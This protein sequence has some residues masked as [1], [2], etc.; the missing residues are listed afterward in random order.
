M[1]KVSI[2][3]QG[4]LCNYLFQ[5]AAA[6]SYAE[7]TKKECV[8]SI[9]DVT[10]VH[11]HISTYRDNILKNVDFVDN[12]N[13]NGFKLYNEPCFSYI[14]I[15]KID[16]DVYLQGYFQSEKYFKEYENE[17]RNIFQIPINICENISE[18]ALSK[19][20]VDIIKDDTCSIHVR[21][22][23]YQCLLLS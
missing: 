7:K 15:P 16:G 8:F 3:L 11:K 10:T 6:Y 23:D 19:F 22:G 12:A 18:F 20:N 5:I 13:F 14:E 9:G 21:R 1:N 4:G 17:I 2:K